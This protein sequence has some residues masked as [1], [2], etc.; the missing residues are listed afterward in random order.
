MLSHKL[1]ECH[2]LLL[3]VVDIEKVPVGK[4]IAESSKVALTEF[5][6]VNLGRVPVVQRRGPENSLV[7]TDDLN[8]YGGGIVACTKLKDLVEQ[9]DRWEGCEGPVSWLVTE[10]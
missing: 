8:S 1:D 3:T 10:I 7:V 5:L 6:V 9:L 4:S 2:R